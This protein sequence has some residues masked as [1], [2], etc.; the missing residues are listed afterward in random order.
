MPREL[1]WIHSRI[2]AFGK[3]ERLSNWRAHVGVAK[4]GEHASVNV[5]D[6]RMDDALGM[7]DDLDRF[8]RGSEQP[9]GLDYFEPLIHHRRRIHTDLAAHDPVRVGACFIRRHRREVRG[10]ACPERSARSGEQ[11]AANA[12][13][14]RIA[15][16]LQRQTLK[17]R[18]VLTVDRQQRCATRID[19]LHESGAADHQRFLVGE[20]DS[21]ARAC[22]GERRRESGG[23][24]DRSEHGVHFGK[25]CHRA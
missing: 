2:D 6:Q 13:R 5:F 11:D 21:L 20:Q 3:R 10:R 9:V 8:S 19:R 1:E 12:D 23:T 16:L 22:G 15:F 24:H 14:R 18:I 25:C 17:D 7:D 4:L